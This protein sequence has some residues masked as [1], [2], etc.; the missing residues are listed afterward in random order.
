MQHFWRPW[1]SWS[2]D[3]SL[4]WRHPPHRPKPLEWRFAR[5]Y[6]FSLKYGEVGITMT[7]VRHYYFVNVFQSFI[8]NYNNQSCSYNLC[9][10]CLRDKTAGSSLD[11]YYWSVIPFFIVYWN[12]NWLTCLA[13]IG[14]MC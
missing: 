14:E 12:L 9:V 13:L 1:Y 2:S 6:K 7:I 5:L 4:V 3:T 11:D 10:I 8:I